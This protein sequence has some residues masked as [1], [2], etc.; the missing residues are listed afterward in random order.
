M[1]PVIR[2][3]RLAD[4]PRMQEIENDAGGLFEGWGLVDF[5]DLA[6]VHMSEHVDSIVAGLSFIA[7]TN[8]RAAGF[9]MGVMYGDDAYL[10]E[11]DVERASQKKGLGAA[12][13]WAFIDAARA[14]HADTV[15]LSTFRD[16]PWN[17]P[18][19]AR[20]GFREVAR[21]N[22]LP[23]MTEIETQQAQFLDIRTRVFMCLAL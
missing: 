13:V 19:Y 4:I 5:D 22:Y 8:G 16:P 1:K 17:A 11:L 20:L 21:S 7:E 3:A 14:K 18:F 10:H 23:W 9:V 12:L 6:V 15:Y 2:P